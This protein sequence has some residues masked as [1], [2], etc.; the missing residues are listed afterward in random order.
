MKQALGLME[1]AFDRAAGEGTLRQVW[2]RDDDAV[3]RGPRLDRLARLAADAGARLALAVIPAGAERALIDW[4][5]DEA[6]AVLQHGV[7]H[8]NNQPAGKA[9]ELG[10]ARPVAAIIAE[11]VAARSR[12]E[13]PAFLPVM[14]PPWNRMR[15]DLAGPLRSAGYVGVSLFGEGPAGD[16]LVRIDTHLDPIAWRAGRG[17]ADDAALAGMVRRGHAAGGPLGLLTHHAVHTGAV[18]DF[19]AAFAWLVADHPGAA[20]ADPR[21][22]FA[23]RADPRHLLAP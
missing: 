20:W 11:A 19:V 2:W 6:I 14:V 3:R 13:G 18:D 10:E 8:A 22:L 17:L 23:A 16:P 21:H 15:A 1:A 7:S 12:I 9:A 5:A 4:C